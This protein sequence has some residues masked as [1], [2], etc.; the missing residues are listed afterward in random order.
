MFISK[1]LLI[2]L[3]SLVSIEGCGLRVL[4]VAHNYHEKINAMETD[5]KN[6]VKQKAI[7]YWQEKLVCHIKKVPI[8][9]VNGL[10]LSELENETF[11]WFEDLR[12]PGKKE[13]LFIDEIFDIKDY[14]DEVGE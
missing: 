4:V 12:T 7:F 1:R 10:I 9:F 11:Y 3:H 2:V 13:R 6:A 14:E 5:N 8:G